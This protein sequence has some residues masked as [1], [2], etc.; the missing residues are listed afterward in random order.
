LQIEERTK[1]S[2]ALTCPNTL[3]GRVFETPL[4]AL[5]LQKNSDKTYDACPYCLTDLKLANSSRVPIVAPKVAQVEEEMQVEKHIELPD[6]SLGCNYHLGYLSER[7][8]KEQIPNECIVCKE[9]VACM[10]KK[11]K[12]QVDS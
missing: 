12:G 10:L 8:S 1:Q 5:N 7:S 11:M 4:K 6:Q 3:C 2:S 9:I